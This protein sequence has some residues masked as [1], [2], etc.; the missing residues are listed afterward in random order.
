MKATTGIDAVGGDSRG[1]REDRRRD[2]AGERDDARP[3]RRA[4]QREHEQR[5]GDR[6]RLRAGRREQLARLQQHEVA[7]APER[8]CPGGA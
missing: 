4:G 7:V 5:V 1:E 6:R 2:D 8:P 3:R